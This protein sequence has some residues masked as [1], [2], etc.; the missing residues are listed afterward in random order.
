MD[1]FS[2]QLDDNGIVLNPTSQVTPF[3][4]ITTIQGIDSPEFRSTERDHEGADGGFLDAEFEKMRT[5][6]LEGQVIGGDDSVESL[7]DQLKA[8]WSP[9][10]STI[11][12]YYSHPGAGDRVVFVKPLGVK[13][14][15]TTLRRIGSCDVQFTCEAEDPIIYDAALQTFNL[16]QGLAITNGF[17]FSLGFSFGFGSS[18]DPNQSNVFNGG[19]RP[20][21]AIITIPGPVSDPVI[22]NDTTGNTLSFD[23]D[24]S[25]SDTLV[26]NLFYRTVKLNGTASRRSTLL[27]PDWFLLA[28]GD[29]FLRYRASTA[30]GPAATVSFRN[31]WR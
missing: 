4:D 1:S 17:G 30:G 27:E 21:P 8:N 28:P 26:I 23:I 6:I 13:F 18:V 15:Y 7:L 2:Y 22:F 5:I 12:F 25:A 14:D 20:A 29:N 19:N 9:R 10:R 24:V 3:V 16:G 11:P 31:A